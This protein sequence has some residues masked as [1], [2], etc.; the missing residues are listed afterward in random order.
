MTE[1]QRQVFL[2]AVKYMGRQVRATR[3]GDPFTEGASHIF[4]I[5][6]V[7]LGKDG[8]VIVQGAA[9]SIHNPGDDPESWFHLWVNPTTWVFEEVE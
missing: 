1:E 9:R 8:L 2:N 3:A 5:D 7:D 6:T 4:M